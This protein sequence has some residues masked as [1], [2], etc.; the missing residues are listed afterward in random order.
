LQNL[1][2]LSLYRTYFKFQGVL[3][4]VTYLLKRV[5]AEF[6]SAQITFALHNKGQSK[7]ELENKYYDFKNSHIYQTLK[8]N[9]YYN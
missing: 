9:K 4:S 6:C 3:L 8:P 1:N 2:K 7:L 5:S